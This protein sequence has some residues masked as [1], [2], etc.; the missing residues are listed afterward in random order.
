MADKPLVS[1]EQEEVMHRAQEVSRLMGNEVVQKVFLD[2][3]DVNLEMWR[4]TANTP[5][6]REYHWLLDRCVTSVEDMLRAVVDNG[7]K[8]RTDIE[9][10]IQRHP[11]L[12]PTPEGD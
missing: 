4:R 12:D 9:R 1:W 5:E 6:D 2:I 11:E 7:I 10:M 8:T 3:K